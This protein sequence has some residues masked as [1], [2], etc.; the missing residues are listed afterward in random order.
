MEFKITRKEIEEKL[1]RSGDYVKMDLLQSYLKKQIDFDTKR[2]CM[3]KL[4]GIYES[5]RMFL[6]AAKLVRNVADINTTFDGK[7]H[8]FAKSMDLYIKGGNYD[9]AELSFKKALAC[10]TQQ[11][12]LA[13]KLRLKDI[14]NRQAKEFL[15][16]DKRKNAMQVYEKMLTLD[17]D[18]IER[19][20]V[21]KSLVSL[22]H[23]LGKIREFYSI[24]K[25]MDS[26]QV[27]EKEVPK[28]NPFNSETFDV[29]DFLN[30]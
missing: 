3:I 24:Q 28:K 22:Y 26:P 12:K 21:Q 5:R 30:K 9:E 14:Y 4:S 29:E 20:E 17:L 2:F 19:R 16:K 18:Q 6:E 25:S 8:D 1:A 10:G 27:L 15:S 7:Y 23:K 13:L 11:Q